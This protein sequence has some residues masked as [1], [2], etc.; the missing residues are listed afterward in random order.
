M[1]QI[2]IPQLDRGKDV[3]PSFIKAICY[4]CPQLGQVFNALQH[5][6]PLLPVNNPQREPIN[7]SFSL[8]N[9]VISHLDATFEQKEELASWIKERW[10]LLCWALELCKPPGSRR[11]NQRVIIW[12]VPIHLW[13]HCTFDLRAHQWGTLYETDSRTQQGDRVDWGRILAFVQ[14][15]IRSKGNLEGNHRNS[16]KCHTD[17]QS[18]EFAFIKGSSKESLRALTYRE[19]LGGMVSLN[20]KG[21]RDS[22]STNR[23]PLSSPPMSRSNPPSPVFGYDSPQPDSSGEDSSDS[24]CSISLDELGQRE[25]RKIE[26]EMQKFV[27]PS[28][29]HESLS[30][31]IRGLR[32]PH[33][34]AA[35]PALSRNESGTLVLLQ[36][37]KRSSFDPTFIKS[38]F[39]L[40]IQFSAM[41]ILWVLRVVFFA[42]SILLD[43]N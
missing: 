31:K 38:L 13:G 20:T 24:Y 6:W 9:S 36:E 8:F 28:L 25:Q 34:V 5:K 30:W 26:R 37:T 12:G 16:L 39:L 32:A 11:L 10:M 19:A 27:V 43:L 18:R 22:S 21:N 35:P 7:A 14:F 29:R 15:F 17:A 41:W 3:W 33:K 42:L 1:V 40:Q 2:H 4:L 23:T